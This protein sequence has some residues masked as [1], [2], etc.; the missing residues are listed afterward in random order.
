MHENERSYCYKE[1]ALV[2]GAVERYIPI[3]N[4]SLGSFAEVKVIG[5]TELYCYSAD[6]RER[7]EKVACISV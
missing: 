5:A 4:R 3:I 6:I 1:Q 2:S 7:G